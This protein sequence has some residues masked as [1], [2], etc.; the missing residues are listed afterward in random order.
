MLNMHLS[1]RFGVSAVSMAFM[2]A[3]TLLLKTDHDLYL[4][5]YQS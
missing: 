3:I 5:L 2:E 1:S 4:K